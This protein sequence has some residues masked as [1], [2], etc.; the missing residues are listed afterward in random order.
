METQRFHNASFQPGRT[1]KADVVVP[2]GYRLLANAVMI[3]TLY[4]IQTN[5]EH[6]HDPFRFDPER[7][8]TDEVKKDRHRGAYMPFATGAR[9]CI[10]FNFALLEVKILV[11]E[12]VYRQKFAREGLEAISI[13]PSSS[14]SSP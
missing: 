7:W 8:D 6:W 1:T 12:L 9:S 11:S 3:P 13:T 14:S 2:G 4:A 5:P 10:G